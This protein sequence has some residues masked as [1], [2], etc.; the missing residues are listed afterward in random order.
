MLT[1]GGRRGGVVGEGEVFMRKRLGK[2]EIL[3]NGVH[4]RQTDKEEEDLVGCFL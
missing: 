4:S 3:I 1:V 2:D